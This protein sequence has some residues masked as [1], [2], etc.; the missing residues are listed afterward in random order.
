MHLT[1]KAEWD[2]KLDCMLGP[3]KQANVFMVRSLNGNW[4]L[5]VYID[6]EP[7]TNPN[8]PKLP[9]GTKE[10]P[11]IPKFLLMQ[12]II[13]LEAIGVKVLSTVSDMGGDNQGLANDLRITPDNITFPNPWDPERPIYFAYD[14]V[15]SFKNLRNHLLDDR[16]TINGVTVSKV[17][18]LKL[19]GKT[20]KIKFELY[21]FF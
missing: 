4:K 7:T 3:N 8:D 14:W 13:Q 12:I 18:I 16:V 10:L 9:K 21:I 6:F 20:G 19:R 1:R 11:K 2:R 17:D 15:H 5:P